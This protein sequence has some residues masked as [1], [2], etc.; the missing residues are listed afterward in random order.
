MGI[1]FGDNL[2]AKAVQA[3]SQSAAGGVRQGW[4]AAS[5]GGVNLNN[6]EDLKEKI[7]S[8]RKQGFRQ[9]VLSFTPPPLVVIFTERPFGLVLNK[10]T[11]LGLNY[12]SDATAN[13]IAKGIK[14][15]AVISSVAGQDVTGMDY[16]DVTRLLRESELPATVVFEQAV[17]TPGKA[18]ATTIEDSDGE[19]EQPN[20]PVVLLEDSKELM[21]EQEVRAPEVKRFTL[22]L[23]LPLGIGFNDVLDAKEVKFGSQGDR[24]GVRPGWKAHAIG[25]R[26]VKT[27]RELVEQIKDLK[28]DM[29]TEVEIV[30]LAP[31]E[32]KNETQAEEEEEEAPP[33]L[34]VLTLDLAQPLGVGFSDSLLAKEVKAGSQAETLGVCAGWRLQQIGD[35]AVAATKELVT[36][37]KALKAAG[38]ATVT[39]TFQLP[40]DGAEPASKRQK[41]S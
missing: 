40:R 18:E 22:D 17:P 16:E 24:L 34:R 7:S 14:P 32:A 41:T 13:A 25:G 5:I 2:V 23:T 27:T 37:M 19:D 30:F 39:I 15:G 21:V 31:Y 8:L 1:L 29:L 9:A 35:K 26:Q 38:T 10:D 6:V 28:L 36:E 4:R 11:E 3:G 12:V 33:E 20:A